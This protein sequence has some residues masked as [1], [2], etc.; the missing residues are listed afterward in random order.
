MAPKPGS[1]GKTPRA[2]KDAGEFPKEGA[3]QLIT[4]GDIVAQGLEVRSA[5]DTARKMKPNEAA[6]IRTAKKWYNASEKVDSSRSALTNSW[7]NL[8]TYWGGHAYTAF[9]NYMQNDAIPACDRNESTLFE[10]G[11]ALVDLYNAA[12]NEYADAVANIGET[13]SRS[14]PLKHKANEDDTSPEYHELYDIV[15]GFVAHIQD[16]KAEIIKFTATFQSAMAE[17]SGRAMQIK[18]PG[19]L[20][21]GAGDKSKWKPN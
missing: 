3:T 5:I 1:G 13:L 6:I 15:V 4:I 7:N 21:S 8:G 10:I 12:A 20:P 18:P 2:S 19:A 16:K 9:T 11:N 17:L 14:N